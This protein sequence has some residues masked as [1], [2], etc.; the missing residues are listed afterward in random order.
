MSEKHI[1]TGDLVSGRAANPV[2]LAPPLYF[3]G[4]VTSVSADG[5]IAVVKLAKP[6]DGC[7]CY[8]SRVTA[9]AA[10]LE[11]VEGER[12]S[13]LAATLRRELEEEQGTA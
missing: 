4:L 6:H 1:S 9:L 10:E 12:W 7:T 5:T 11:K 3:I 2:I 8:L 13:N